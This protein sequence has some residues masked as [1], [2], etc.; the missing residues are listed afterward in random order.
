MIYNYV[1]LKFIEKIKQSD[2][3]EKLNKTHKYDKYKVE[4]LI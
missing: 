3:I 4:F 2:L 1:Y